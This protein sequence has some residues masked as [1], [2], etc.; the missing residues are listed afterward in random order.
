MIGLIGRTVGENQTSAARPV[1]LKFLG[2][3]DARGQRFE[4]LIAILNDQVDSLG[5]AGGCEVAS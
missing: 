1:S 2:W 5:G 4:R 3:P